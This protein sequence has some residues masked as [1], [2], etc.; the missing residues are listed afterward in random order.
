MLMH[1]VAE[2]WRGYTSYL[3]QNIGDLDEKARFFKPEKVSHQEDY[4]ILLKDNQEPQ[5]IQQKI[6]RART[7]LAAT[8]QIVF[9]F[10]MCCTELDRLEVLPDNSS[11]LCEL[12]GITATLEYDNAVL[13]ELLDHSGRTID[14]VGSNSLH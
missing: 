5:K 4:S 2:G 3:R 1:V 10:Q 9:R 7:V 12:E 11:L 14:L 13:K 8:S 6:C